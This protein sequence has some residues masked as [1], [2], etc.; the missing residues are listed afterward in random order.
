LHL[1]ASPARAGPKRIEYTIPTAIEIEGCNV[2]HQPRIMTESPT[3]PVLPESPG[4][5]DP[6]SVQVSYVHV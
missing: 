3:L 1:L 6:I 4:K 2:E 5:T